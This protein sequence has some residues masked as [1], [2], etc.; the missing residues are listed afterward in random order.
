MHVINTAGAAS[1]KNPRTD[2]VHE[3]GLDGVFTDI[4][5]DF[6]H[7]LV[8]RHASQWREASAHEAALRQSQVEKMRNPHLVAP[9]LADH[10]SRI[11]ELEARVDALL[12]A[13]G[14]GGPE[15]EPTDD[16]NETEARTVEQVEP[17]APKRAAKKAAARK[18]AAPKDAPAE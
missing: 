1:V 11:G 8:T 6:A 2:V 4:P 14:G 7:E 13:Q 15:R 16:A 10:A 9:T 18:T 3:A 5:L 17:G 12:A